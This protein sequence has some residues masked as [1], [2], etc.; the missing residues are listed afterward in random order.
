MNVALACVQAV[1]SWRFALWAEPSSSVMVG[2]SGSA[3]SIVPLVIM[4]HRTTEGRIRAA[5]EELAQLS[6]VR[7]PRVCLPVDD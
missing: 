4:T 5:D 2:L 7:Q 6:S 3:E 1:E